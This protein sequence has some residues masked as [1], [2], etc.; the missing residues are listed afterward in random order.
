MNCPQ[1]VGAA[2]REQSRRSPEAPGIEAGNHDVAIGHQD[3]LH[4]AEQLV[5][6]VAE[7]ERVWQHD[8]IDARRRNAEF[9]EVGTDA[10]RPRETDRSPIWHA[11]GLEKVVLPETE[12]Q[13]VISEH[14]RDLGI[15][16]RALPFHQVSTQGS[17]EPVRQAGRGIRG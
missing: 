3:A 9:A 8:E 4:F 16:E 14:V 7:L 5:R 10:R 15:E 1:K 13:R 6:V 12:L 17:G 2:T 11:V